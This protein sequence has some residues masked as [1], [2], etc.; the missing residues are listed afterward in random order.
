ME[1]VKLG[2]TGLDVSR[3]CLGCMSYGDPGRGSH[4]WTLSEDK[5][6]PIIRKA[7]DSGVNFFDT[8]N[9]Y[10][11]GTSEE[12]IG[13]A[14]AATGN[15]DELVIATKVF[16]TMR[17][18]PNGGGLSRKAILSEIDHSLRRLGTDYVDLYQIHR[19]DPNTPLEE[20]LE[21]L[22]DVVKAGKVRYIGASSMFAWQFSK[23]LYTSQA[24]GWTRF[25]T[26]QNHYNL[27]YREEE[28]EMLSLCQDQGIGVLPWS[29]LA[30][31]RLTR[32][33]DATSS[34]SE[35]DEFGKGLYQAGDQ[36]VVEAV[37]RIAAARG[38]PRAQ[39]ALAWLASRPAVTA[40]IV[41]ATK[42]QHI[43][44]AIAALEVELTD[45]EIAELEAP[46]TPHAVAGF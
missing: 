4:E 11:D 31:G 26:M 29:P 22:H 19:W 44:D 13:R 18:G 45:A 30:R 43:D 20:T 27:L 39:V 36:E 5:S 14:L 33:W 41:G 28:R 15:R 7:L 6:L 35:T 34:R 8:A 25:A 46:Y 1:Y 42:Q 37:A 2:S 16:G 38:I 23:A 10:S 12:I 40:P 32:N 17:P 3:V 24:N 9:V 21:A